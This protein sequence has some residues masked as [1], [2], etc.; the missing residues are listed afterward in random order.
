M[1][2]LVLTHKLGSEYD[3]LPEE[4]YHFPKKYLKLVQAGIGHQ[5]VYYRPRRGGAPGYFA[6]AII[7]SIDEDPERVGHFYA[8]IGDYVDFLR[9]VPWRDEGG[10]REKS[11]GRPDGTGS[12]GFYGWSV[13]R[14]S[15]WELRAIV[16][17]GMEA[18]DATEKVAED[19]T[20]SEERQRILV[21]T[22]RLE[23]D[24]AFSGN[25]LDSYGYRCAATG[26]QLAA[27]D[28]RRGLQAAHI[29][30]AGGEHRGP[31]STRN[32][33]ALSP[34]YHWLMDVGLMRVQLE[35][36]AASVVYSTDLHSE[37]RD[38]LVPE[39]TPIQLPRD[40]FRR[41]HPRFLQYHRDKIWE[42]WRRDRGRSG[43]Q[44]PPRLR[45]RAP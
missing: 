23:R 2:N 10:F 3:D 25:V 45:G 6:T 15:A 14:I 34:S 5:L 28:G 43:N 44:R 27:P 8:R 37:D 36:D 7:Q 40:P 9:F 24:R 11:G 21:A 20:E 35:D 39:G 33:I 17:T 16:A 18:S 38:K 29:R 12:R 32:G 1:A 26:L 22:S 4:R 42:R 31:D 30:P 41:P 13:R 19:T